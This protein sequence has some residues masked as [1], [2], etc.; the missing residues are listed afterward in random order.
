MV[1]CGGIQTWGAGF[2]QLSTL[3][4]QECGRLGMRLLRSKCVKKSAEGADD[5][6]PDT[7]IHTLNSTGM[8]VVELGDG[9]VTVEVMGMMAEGGRGDN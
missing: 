2:T 6:H 1:K 5:P 7:P 3:H 8:M 4:Y 9:G